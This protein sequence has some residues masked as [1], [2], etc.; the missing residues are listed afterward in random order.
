[1]IEQPEQ[2]IPAIN[3]IE[4]YAPVGMFPYEMTWVQRSDEPSPLVNFED[5]NGWTVETYGGAIAELRRSREQQL[6]GLYV[7]KLI[8]SGRSKDSHVIIR[9][10]GPIYISES[11][12][13]ITMWVYGNNWS[14]I[15]DTTTPQV[16][17]S[18][19]LRDASNKGFRVP[20]TTVCWKQW[21]LVHKRVPANILK[22]LHYPCYFS[23]IEVDKGS[24]K[25]TRHLYFDSLAFYKEELKPLKFQPRPRRNLKPWRGQIIGT[26]R[27]PGNLPFPTREE[28]ILPSNY[29]R[30]FKTTV[31]EIGPN[32]YLF[33]YQGSDIRIVYEYAP[34]KGILNE[35]T[36]RV[37]KEN[38]RLMDGGG[39][40]FE[41]SPSG[42]I[43]TGNLEESSLIGN[44]VSAKFK[45]DNHVIEYA[46]RLW[47]KSLVLDVWCDGGEAIELVFGKV[48]GTQSPK[49][50]TV[51]YI[52][53]S[54]TNPRVL[55]SELN[56]KP[57]FTSIWWDWYRTNA[58]EPFANPQIDEHG[59]AEING[60]LRYNPKA[61]GQRNN[62]Y[63]RIFLTVS[64]I[65]EEVLPTIANPPAI[66]GSGSA[67]RIWTVTAP[68]DWKK[69]HARCRRIRSYG[70]D[71]V[72]QHSHEVTWR[73]EGES[74]TL[75]LRASP[76]KGGDAMLKWYIM[77]Q[78]SLGWRQGMYSNY[79]DYCP[80]NTHF[81]EAGVQRLPN[82]EWRKAWPRNYAM[83]PSK[84]V[85][86]DAEL[87]KQIQAKFNSNFSY[88]DV[89]TA[90]PPWFYCDYDARVPGAGT[91]AATFYAYGEILLNDQKVYG[92]T[93]SE[94]TYQWLYAGLV[95]G[96]YGWCY[97][98]Y[99]LLEEPL[100][101]A[102]DLL[103][104]H[105]LETDYG[106]GSFDYYLN[107]LDPNWSK[108]SKRDWYIDRVMASTIAYGHNGFL[109]DNI[110]EVD[111]MARSYYMMQ[112]L[113]QRYCM[114]PP[115]KIEYAD[116]AGKVM[117]VS[118]ALATDIIRESRLHIIYE[119]GLEIYVNG[120]GSSKSSNKNWSF[121]T[122]DGEQV[123][124]PPAGWY[125]YD[126]LIKLKEISG[127]I[128]EHRIDYVISPEYEFLDGRGQWT[129]IGNL[130]VSGA[131]VMRYLGNDRL[132]LIDIYG[133]KQIGFKVNA[134]N[135][136]M[137]AYDEEGK[138]LGGVPVTLTKDRYYQ[139]YPVVN[140][141]RYV[142]TLRG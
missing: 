113:Q 112:Q 71:K 87:A 30:T 54:S 118:E 21:W 131:V 120:N 55:M 128:L 6:W 4:K 59:S 104:I 81:S 14:F 139:F 34:A 74:F 97:T 133:N 63:E 36:V 37:G 138:C 18:I 66:G 46:L 91:M 22:R 2:V 140:G 20:F 68:E 94:G 29:E 33:D 24:N 78:R 111:I 95:T 56:G 27:G 31:E 72:M 135:G 105:P 108:S 62:M 102:F 69:D 26:N 96:N 15:E 5:M 64:P 101:V 70:I 49:L 115:R 1:M 86:W 45:V 42:V 43:S 25:D 90:V 85:E 8:Y 44:V 76:Q 73:D 65:Y 58:S 130:A 80:L 136:Q 121:R 41:D 93:M 89:H 47:Q 57:L 60:G 10:P 134:N 122:S 39:V 3:E 103:K 137:M 117:S 129:K 40:R 132:E 75:R 141:R 11:F 52:T 53:Y 50:T 123:E 13:T 109:Y 17:I 119:N 84:G 23:G 92:I 77:A 79:C 124:L 127:L 125:A 114:V 126:P 100:N 19:L 83:K 67:E 106:L 98:N 99:N 142:F 88:T 32:R 7:A 61:D 51:P 116:L 107:S 35:I 82:G 28:T 48:T 110:A 38:F 9:P 12:D 16:E